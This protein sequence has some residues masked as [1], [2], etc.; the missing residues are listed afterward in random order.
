[1]VES[2]VQEHVIYIDI[3]YETGSEI[4]VNT[5]RATLAS[6][7]PLPDWLKIDPNAG[8]L[9]GDVPVDAEV[10]ELRLEVNLSDGTQIVRYVEVQLTNGEIS[11][12]G[13]RPE[14]EVT[15][16]IPFKESL[17]SQQGV[18]ETEVSALFGAL[19]DR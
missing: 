19:G 10:I 7:E 3:D 8:L 14:A 12:L 16:I 6:G 13:G 2:L 15:G 9:I 18:E 1:M 5:Y 11:E 17:E 4:D